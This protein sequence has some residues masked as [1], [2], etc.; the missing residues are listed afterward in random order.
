MKP[1]TFSIIGLGSRGLDAYAPFQKIHP[2]LMKI[3]AVADLRPERIEMAKSEYDIPS[4]MCFSSAEELLEQERLSDA[5]IIASQDQDHVRQALK[6]MDKGYAILL[7]KPISPSLSECMELLQRAEQAKALVTVCHVLRYTPFYRTI[8]KLLEDGKI[9][10]I[11]NIDALE[12]VGYYHM[13]HSFVRGN[14]R[15]SKTTSPMILAKSCHDMDI[16]RYLAD[17]QCDTVSSNGRLS[18]FTRENAPE[19]SAPRCLSGCKCKHSCPFDAEKIYI[20]DERTGYEYNR[21]PAWPVNVL[22]SDYTRDGIYKALREGPYGRCVFHSDNDVVDHQVASI[23]FKNGI[24]ATF[25]MSAFTKEKNRTIRIMGTEGEI[26]ADTDENVIHIMRFDNHD[27]DIKV[28]ESKSGH[29]GGDYNIMMDFINAVK[30]NGRTP[31]DLSASIESHLMCF[32][33]EESRKTGRT[34]SINL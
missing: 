34:I 21:E 17:S 2:E 33:A 32:A 12:C 25:T 16:L 5:I 10:K 24:S 4:E 14:W 19:G 11:M 28:E 29:W 20:T 22:T 15:S 18:F 30:E 23:A 13:A 27:E 7:E 1:V 9:G 8:K 3:T 6:A 31:S 26:Y